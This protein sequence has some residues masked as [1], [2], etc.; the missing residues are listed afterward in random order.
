MTKLFRG[1]SFSLTTMDTGRARARQ[2]MNSWRSGGSGC[3]SND[4]T[5]RAGLCSSRGLKI[6]CKTSGALRHTA[7]A[8]G[9]TSFMACFHPLEGR[10]STFD[11]PCTVRH[12][13]CFDC[14]SS[15]LQGMD[16]GNWRQSMSEF[17]RRIWS[18][19]AGQDIAEYAVMLAVILVLEVDTIRLI[20][21][22]A[23]N[24][25][26]NLASSIQ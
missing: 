16:V 7:L 18:E 20:V 2:S 4:W 9:Y 8:C 23:N 17:I 13:G 5:T 15:R 11:K 10:F 14:S 3:L 22:N 19:D 25:F 24:A 21:F 26:S 12:D 6:S 1:A